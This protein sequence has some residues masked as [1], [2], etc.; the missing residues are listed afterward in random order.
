MSMLVTQ[1][2]P[3]SSAGICTF[4]NAY[5]FPSVVIVVFISFLLRC[6]FEIRKIKGGQNGLLHVGKPPPP[7]LVKAAKGFGAKPAKVV[8]KPAVKQDQSAFKKEPAAERPSPTTQDSEEDDDVVPEV[9]T[10]RILRRLV[11]TV[12]APLLAGLSFFPLFYYLKV[13]KEVSLPE[14]LPLLTSSALFGIAGLGISYG[15][16]SASWDPSR[17]GSLL[18]W[19]EFRQNLPAFMQTL[20]NKK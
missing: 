16:I 4:L 20:G 8:A 14:W 5:V 3:S 18:G 13:V 7:L 9:V 10:N 6:L 2:M 19:K 11:F 17:E 1:R 12:G 15:V